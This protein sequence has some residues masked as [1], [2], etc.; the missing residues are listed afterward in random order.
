MSE[1][2][3]LPGYFYD[4]EKRK[5]F[6]IQANVPS[7]S[8]YSSQDVKRRKLDDADKQAQSLRVQR[9]VGRIKRA[10][11]LKD[12]I[13][14]GFLSVGFGQSGL[15]A[16]A[17]SVYAHSLCNIGDFRLLRGTAGLFEVIPQRSEICDTSVRFTT[18]SGPGIRHHSVDFETVATSARPAMDVSRID[19]NPTRIQGVSTPFLRNIYE[20]Q[21]TSLSVNETHGHVATTWSGAA[22][23]AGIAISPCLQ[24]WNNLSSAQAQHAAR[25]DIV[26]GPGEARGKVDILSSTSAP[27]TSQYTFAIGSSKGVLLIDRNLDTSWIRQQPFENS[28]S[29]PR[30]VFALDFL[31]NHKDILLTGERRGI[32]SITDLRSSHQGLKSGK[33]KHTSCITHI[34]PLDEHRIL[35]AGCAS[36]LCQ[37][38]TRFIKPNT[39]N[40][41][42][43]KGKE[44]RSEYVSAT[45]SCLS[46]PDYVTDGYLI[47]GLDVDLELGVIAVAQNHDK[48]IKLFSLHGGHILPTRPGFGIYEDDDELHFLEPFVG[49]LKFVQDTPNAPKSLWAATQRRLMR[50]SIDRRETLL[51]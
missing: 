3:Q 47:I 41:P 40:A 24:T 8:A 17:T 35:V 29:Y 20:Q 31:P 37:Y 27:P 2:P 45:K 21:F 6:K 43:I 9:N 11:I 28:D 38:D 15:D 30:D 18:T 23:D 49:H 5:Y 34:K 25:T 13:A 14:G 10:R 44:R 33:I 4:S 12:P 36:D 1:A 51:S 46:Y 7:S 19:T 16:I 26:I 32:L 39:F 48:C 42:C 22:A 50:F